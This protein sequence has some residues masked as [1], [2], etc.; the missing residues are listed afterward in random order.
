MTTCNS[1]GATGATAIR[2]RRPQGPIWLTV[3]VKVKGKYDQTIRETEIDGTD[4]AAKHW[5]SLDRQLRPCG[6]F[7]GDS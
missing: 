7:R 2:S 1:P 5:K 3:P 6:L 4:W